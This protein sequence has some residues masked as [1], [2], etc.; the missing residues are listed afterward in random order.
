MKSRT[1]VHLE[2]AE[3]L[4]VLKVARDRSTRDWALILVGYLHACRA[5]ELSNLKLE[6]V[7]LH[8]GSIFIGRLKG[9]LQTTQ[10]LSGHKGQPLLDEIKALRKWL[11]ERPDDG[12]DFLFNSQRG[13]R[14]SRS[15]VFR[16]FQS[17]AE[18]AGLPEDKRHVHVLKHSR[19]SHLVGRMDVALLRQTMGHKNIANTLIYAHASDQMAAKEAQRATMEIF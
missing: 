2:P 10:P 8:H 9:S 5:S 19:A 11:R 7:N 17:C 3:L 14:L 15:Q 12:S 4:A 18:A 16:V 13:G 1:R 6:D